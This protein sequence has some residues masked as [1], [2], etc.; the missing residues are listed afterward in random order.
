MIGSG[1]KIPLVWENLL[2]QKVRTAMG[3]AGIAFAVVLLFMQLG[4][5]GSAAANATIIFEQLHFDLLLLSCDYVRFDQPGFFSPERMPRLLAHPEVAKVVPLHVVAQFWRK[6]QAE[7]VHGASLNKRSILVI[8][9]PPA[10]RAFQL[11]AIVSQ[12]EKLKR[13]GTVLFDRHA[14]LSQFGV[15]ANPAGL[16]NQRYWLGR[17]AVSIVGEYFLGAGLTA[18]GMVVTSDETFAQQAGLSKP[19]VI[20]MGLIQLRPGARASAAAVAAELNSWLKVSTPDVRVWT[21]ETIEDREIN[22]W[23]KDMPIGNI[24]LAGVGVAILVGIVFVYQVISS[25]IAS[26]L[27]EF[28]TLKAIGYGE[29]Y[30]SWTVL[31]Q[32]WLLALFGYVPGLVFS[33]I[34]YVIAHTWA[35][36]PIGFQGEPVLVVLGRCLAVLATT[37]G[38]CSLS[39]LFALFKLR[40][41]DPADLF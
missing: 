22:H 8:G 13:T 9:F 19:G 40:A 15:P 16:V 34:L 7:P 32:S 35:Y 11:P 27:R 20:S 2:H 36:I 29:G 30:M 6:D 31:V 1:G 14:P 21:R 3:V 5:L 17:E 25:D 39:A 26:R 38:L 23:V 24:F 18:N 10:E 28:A 12:Q 37:L 33:L 41:A 4:F